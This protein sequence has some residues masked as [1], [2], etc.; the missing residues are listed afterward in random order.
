[1]GLCLVAVE[2]L[3]CLGY[4]RVQPHSPCRSKLILEGLAYQR[5][6]ELISPDFPGLLLDHPRRQRLVERLQQTLLGH[7]LDKQPQLVKPELTSDDRGDR[8]RLVAPLGEPVQPQAY[9]LSYTLGDA[10]LP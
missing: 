2:R 6:G 5:V 8:E 9:D 1:M 10:D 4:V 3:Q 7:V